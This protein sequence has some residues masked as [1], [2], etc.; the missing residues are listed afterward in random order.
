MFRKRH[1]PA[2]ARP[3]TLVIN[4]DA[5]K[6]T[7]RV[8]EYTAEA[9]Q[10]H[11]LADVQELRGLL[12]RD[13]LSWIDVEG[14]G[15]EQV[16]RS[17]ADIFELHPLALEDV[18]NVPQRPKVENYEKHLLYITRMAILD[19]AY[20]IHAQQI[21]IYLGPNF[22]LTFQEDH[23]DVLDPVRTR[24]RQGKG[25]IR[26]SGPDYL[27]YAIIDAVIDAYY[28]ILE[29]YGEIL[30]SLEDEIVEQP[31]RSILRRIH[32]MKRELLSVRRAIWPQ[33]EAINS[34]IRDENPLISDAVRVYLRDC[35][36]HCIQIIDVVETYRELAS[37]LMDVYLSSLGN[38]TNDVMK[39]LT[40][41]ASIFI[42]LTFMAGV[43]GMNF[44]HMPELRTRYGYPVLMAAMIAVAV[45]MV[46]FF[47]RKGWLGEERSSTGDD[48]PS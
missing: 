4:G 15:D 7:V 21:S 32:Q 17:I 9:V 27:A 20:A 3:G 30:E 35:Y 16:L 34:L 13:S 12:A 10:E 29:S 6:P 47:R 43:Y 44:E 25:P 40:I 26:K 38:R 2:G 24:L 14:L 31:R 36:D 33:R 11:E 48:V 41:M 18:V 39:V 22:V 46:M 8:M 1:P 45:G 19:D 5:S 28:P 37:G 42:P 23:Q